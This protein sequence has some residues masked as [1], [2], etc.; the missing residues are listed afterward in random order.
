MKMYKGY[1][2]ERITR[3]DWNIYK[4]GK[5]VGH[6]RT[7]KEAKALVDLIDREFL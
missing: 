6:T 3:V 4:D 2:I 7:M 1:Q 5:F